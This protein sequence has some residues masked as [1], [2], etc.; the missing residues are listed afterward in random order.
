MLELLDAVDASMREEF[1]LQGVFTWSTHRLTPPA[2]AAQL[3]VGCRPYFIDPHAVLTAAM[4]LV[5]AGSTEQLQ[6]VRARVAGHAALQDAQAA[7]PSGM[8]AAM[9][10][11]PN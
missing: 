1:T 5:E 8:M 3:L 4:E 6:E 7:D 11:A 9:V 2:L 10:G